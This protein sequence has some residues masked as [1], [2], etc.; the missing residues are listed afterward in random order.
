MN[1]KLKKLLLSLGYDVDADRD[2]Y[3]W[4]R[5]QGSNQLR[6]RR[7]KVDDALTSIGRA[8]RSLTADEQRQVDRGKQLRSAL[9]EA[10]ELM[11]E[12]ERIE[13][14]NT[15]SL[16]SGADGSDSRVR[17]SERSRSSVALTSEQSIADHVRSRGGHDSNDAFHGDWRSQRGSGEG[18]SLGRLIRG[19]LTDDWRGGEP[20]RRALWESNPA[21]AGVLVPAPMASNVIDLARNQSRVMRAGAVTVPMESSSLKIARQTGDPSLGWHTEGDT[22]A[23]SN[24]AFDSVTF[25]A[26][27]LPCLVKFSLEMLEDVDNLEN[28]V[29][30]A[31]AKAFGQELDRVALKGSGVDPEPTGILNQSGVTVISATDTGAAT[32]DTLVNGV[33]AVKGN[34]FTPTGQIF[35]VNTEKAVST[36]RENGTTGPYLSPPTYLHAAVRYATKQVADTELY[37]GQ[38]NQLLVGMRTNFKVQPLNEL[39]AET[40]EYGVLCHMRADVQLAHGGAFAV[41]TAIGTV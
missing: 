18:L 27:T 3:S 13:V 7:G 30:A 22:I 14:S 2:R 9:T 32:W 37:T 23:E 28:I 11:E 6:Q 34:N 31:I 33:A 21:S 12:Q 35:S 10:I 26:K 41:H 38:W 15:R 19:M 25:K 39:Y 24:L 20:E 1:P 40:G 17:R 16:G 29:E 5:F 36:L 4:E 8:N